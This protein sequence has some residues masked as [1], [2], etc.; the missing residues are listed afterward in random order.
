MV[1]QPEYWPL[2]IFLFSLL[3]S[4]S[5]LHQILT[6]DSNGTKLSYAKVKR[7]CEKRLQAK[8]RS[9]RLGTMTHTLHCHVPLNT[10]TN[11]T[12]P[13]CNG[14][15]SFS[16]SNKVRNEIS[17]GSHSSSC[18]YLQS[19]NQTLE[20]CR[21]PCAKI[22]DCI[23]SLFVSQEYPSM[24]PKKLWEDCSISPLHTKYYW[25]S[26]LKPNLD[27]SS[28]TQRCSVCGF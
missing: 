24:P 7:H 8:G 15:F 22:Q 14:D 17:T 1:I 4:V 21:G 28:F 16:F 10:A 19:Q 25:D 11:S 6:N 13:V 9:R 2:S 27:W 23:V 12:P 18:R 3:I 20:S 26:S 5:L